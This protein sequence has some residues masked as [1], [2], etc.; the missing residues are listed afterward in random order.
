MHENMSK[1]EIVGSYFSQI[2]MLILIITWDYKFDLVSTKLDSW[3]KIKYL[4]Q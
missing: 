4:C 3:F 1:R 2:V